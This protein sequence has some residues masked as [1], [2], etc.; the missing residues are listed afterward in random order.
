M[1][2]RK[3]YQGMKI[4]QIKIDCPIQF[5]FGLNPELEIQTKYET[6]TAIGSYY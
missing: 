6:G 4:L 3:C 2:T 5:L 1:D